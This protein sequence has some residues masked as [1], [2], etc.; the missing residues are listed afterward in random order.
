MKKIIF[1][2]VITLLIC[3]TFLIKQ[4]NLYPSFKEHMGNHDAASLVLQQVK[5]VPL[6][7]GANRLDYQSIDYTTNRLYISHLGSS[8]VHVFDLRKQKI[9]KDIS[10]ASNPYGIL[11]VPSLKTVYVGI[12]GNN[13]V[14]VIDENTLQV[15][16]YIQAG[17]TPD[18]IAYNPQSKEV[19]VSNE[20]GGTVSV[21]NTKANDHITDIQ[22]GGAVGNTQ[23]F[24]GQNRIY[25]AAG[26]DNKLIEIDPMQNKVVAKYNLPGCSH[27]HGFYIDP[28]TSYA[29]ITCDI[30]NVMLVFDLDTKKVISSYTVGAGPDVLAYDE[31]LHHL[32]VAAESGV[33]T[34]FDVKKNNVKKLYEGFVAPHSHTV[35]VD[36]KT[37]FVYLPLENING[38]P[39]LR[40]MKP[41]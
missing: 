21:I 16:K 6:A 41:Y 22:I 7:G 30:N 4:L 26:D 1:A 19:F 33:L 24:S 3:V 32:Y 2:I 37:H 20:N 9:V 10:L 28:Q 15:T 29:F 31:G 13:Q 5:D 40:I 14:A 27:P 18:G 23:N 34:I 25:T 12:G 39:V 8:T 36:Q 17:E 11:A 38:K 35:A